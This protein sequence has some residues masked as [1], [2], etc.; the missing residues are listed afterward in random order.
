MH[1]KSLH[2]SLTLY[3][4]FHNQNKQTW[5]ISKFRSHF[6]SIEHLIYLQLKSCSLLSTISISSLEE[7]L[8]CLNPLHCIEKL[9]VLLV[10]QFFT[11]RLG[12]NNRMNTYDKACK[13]STIPAK[14]APAVSGDYNVKP[15]SRCLHHLRTQWKVDRRLGTFDISNL[16]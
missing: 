13:D 8:L 1:L 10:S 14:G 11:K 5:K 7:L 12:F 9:L 2:D 6:D 4:I 16:K 3:H 15:Q